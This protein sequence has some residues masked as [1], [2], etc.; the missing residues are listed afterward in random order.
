[1]N[2]APPTRFVNAAPPP[3]RV[4][5]AHPPEKDGCARVLALTE[6]VVVDQLA[7]RGA[8]GKLVRLATAARAGLRVPTGIVLP[9]ELVAS[10]TPGQLAFATRAAL[11]DRR[12]PG[13]R[14]RR[15]HQNAQPLT[16]PR[17]AVRSAFSGEDGSTTSHAGAFTSHL[18]VAVDDAGALTA[19][20]AAV[21]A[22]AE[23][24]EPAP[25][26]RDV[27]V[28]A[29][30]PAARAGVAFTQASFQDDLVDHTAGLGDQLLG[31]AV[32]GGREQLA[33]R[34][35][36]E[37][38]E[39]GWRGRLQGLL[40]D[41]RRVFGPGDWDVEWADDGTRCWLLQVRPITAPPRRDEAL[42]LANHREILPDLPSR[43]T[44]A[45]L[46]AA[47]G[48]LFGYW[49]RF[50][51]NLPADRPFVEVVLWRP[52]INLSLLTDTMRILGLPT[53]FVTRS[54]GGQDE[55]DVPAAPLRLLGKSP[56]QLAMGLDQLRAVGNG[57]ETAGRLHTLAATPGDDL[58]TVADTLRR[59]TVELIT[60]MFAL[61]T[62][63]SGPLAVL[64]A[65]G[66][67]GVLHTRQRTAATLL[68]EELDQ[69]RELVAERPAAADALR[70]GALR[71][72][73]VRTGDA[74]VDAALT[75][76]LSRHGHRGIYESDVARPRYAEDPAPLLEA[77]V[78]GRAL[79]S[80]PA[81]PLRARLAWPLWWQ[82]S[83]AMGAREELRSEAMKAFGVVRRRLLELA[84]QHVAAGRLP[85][86]A[87]VFELDL[88]ELAALDAGGAYTATALAERRAELDRL[89]GYLLPDLLHR[90]DDVEAYRP[91]AQADHDAIQLAG[92]GL[93]G[94]SVTGTAWV[95]DEPGPP[96][97]ELEDVPVVLVAR[98]VD[99]GW[100]ATFSR[101][102]AVIVETGGELSHG[103]ILLRESGTPAVTNVTGATRALQTGDHIEVRAAAGVV[104][105]HVA[106]SS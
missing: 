66:V 4:S 57:R 71:A 27:L 35:R 75:A 69:L 77:V 84:G 58:V 65:L 53:A 62:A 100:L 26:R 92:L 81:L 5:T 59:C 98:G 17:V 16:V 19:A 22:S 13:R 106:T 96:P 38:T 91:G 24:H 1:M 68:W 28:L 12:A 94:G 40:R 39:A 18:D 8:S 30:V 72:D 52:V 67:A 10:R 103:S 41:V 70:A 99:A 60:G 6:P 74:E 48:E 50:D 102:A 47:A 49:R 15:Q 78:H 34:V 44:T 55:L 86:A 29:M 32:T 79:A 9:A 3:R 89:S 105:R 82:A 43:L 21:L 31:G 97:A 36:G 20:V 37:R 11:G 101:V 33:I 56:R 90:S 54:M 73:A 95:A 61:S 93:T 25:A 104:L 63:I 76:L 83:R 7:E 51:P 14:R 42:T 87:A 80:P 64:D 85:E 23:Q 45:T 46:A 2:A 88:D